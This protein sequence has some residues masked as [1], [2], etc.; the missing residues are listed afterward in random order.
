MLCRPR[1]SLFFGRTGA[2]KWVTVPRGTSLSRPHPSVILSVSGG[3]RRI[4]MYCRPLNLTLCRPRKS[5]VYGLPGAKKIGRRPTRNV[6]FST[7]SKCHFERVR[8]HKA[9]PQVLPPLNLTL[10]RT[11]KSLFLPHMCKKIGPSPTRKVA[12]STSSKCNFQG[13]RK[14]KTRP[15]ALPTP[16]LNALPTSKF[17]FFSRTGAKKLDTVPRESSLN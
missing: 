11:R 17:R 6:A 15:Q 4:R 12:F 1:R 9:R 5:H 7:S 10:C 16:Y 14:T 13:F 3:P 2:K 8:R